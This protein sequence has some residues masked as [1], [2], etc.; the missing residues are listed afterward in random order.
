MDSWQDRI[1]RTAVFC[2]CRAGGLFQDVMGAASR[3]PLNREPLTALAIAVMLLAFA[4]DRAEQAA[5][6]HDSALS[7]LKKLLQVPNSASALQIRMYTESSQRP[8]ICLQI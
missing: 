6:R 2:G 5:L 1:S 7:V 8:R 3:L 4:K